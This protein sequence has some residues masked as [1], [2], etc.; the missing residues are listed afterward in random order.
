MAVGGFFVLS[1]FLITR[2]YEGTLTFGRF[3]WHRVLRI[4]PGFWICLLVGAF[5]VAPVAFARE[6][7]SLAGFFSAQNGPASYVLRNGLLVIQQDSIASLFAGAPDP[8]A[9]NSSLWTLAYEFA[10]YLAIGALGA[11]LVLRRWRGAVAIGAIWLFL[12]Y[13]LLLWQYGARGTPIVLNMVSLFVYFGFGASAYLFRD[14][15][16]MRAWIAAL[17]AIALVAAVPTR[18]VAIA[19]PVCLSY[20]TLYAAQKVPVR[21]FDRHADLSYGLY[22]YAFPIQQMLVLYG[23]NRL[24]LT[25]YFAVG[26]GLSLAF[27]AASWFAVERPCL[28]LKNAVMPRVSV[29]A[30]ER[31]ST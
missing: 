26:L 28:A 14:R 9:F 10:C 20:L 7:G 16:P 23:L 1:G 15:I 8:F 3:L 5:V 12:A 2:S 6:H 13:A 29:G 24:G 30:S 27:A 25:P 4:F 17:F 21:N 22:I 19:V 18:A 11:A 31:R